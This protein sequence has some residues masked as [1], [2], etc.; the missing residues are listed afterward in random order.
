MH[1]VGPVVLRVYNA[2]GAALLR[3][4]KDVDEVNDALA[5]MLEE[6][7]TSVEA[8]LLDAARQVAI[9]TAWR[10]SVTPAERTALRRVLE[11]CAPELRSDG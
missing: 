5:G 8:R 6:I 1:A 9:K 10:L 3:K 7:G 11:G 2:V 4:G